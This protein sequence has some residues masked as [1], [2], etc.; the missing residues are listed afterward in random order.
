MLICHSY[1]IAHTRDFI[2]SGAERLVLWDP[3]KAVVAKQFDNLPS[4]ISS[5]L[6]TD[7]VIYAGSK[8]AIYCYDHRSMDIVTQMTIPK[9]EV[10]HVF[11]LRMLPNSSVLASLGSSSNSI[12][13]WDCRMNQLIGNLKAEEDH[14]SLYSFEVMINAILAGYSD[15]TLM[16]MNFG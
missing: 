2:A 11:Q 4:F 15:G 13:F 6:A 14:S 10:G 8:N 3:N 7:T 12:Q 5:M 16:E 9:P 1:C